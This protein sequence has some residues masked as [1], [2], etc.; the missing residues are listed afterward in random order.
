MKFTLHDLLNRHRIVV[1]LIQR[2]Y[3]Q[4]RVTEVDLRKNFIGKIKHSLNPK[5]IPLNLDFVYG[6]TDKIGNDETIFIPLD[7]QQRLTTL[8]LTYWYLAPRES[9]KIN[10][11]DAIQ[12]SEEIQELL[13]GFTYETRISS[14]RFCDS[15]INKSL[16]AT[17]GKF[18]SELI[19]DASWYMASWNS[20]PTIISMLNMID[21]IQNENFDKEESWNQLVINKKV[22]FDYID[23]KSDE[24]KLTDELYIKMNSR[25]KPL[26]SFENFKAQFSG[27]LSSKDTNYNEESLIFQKSNVTYQ[28]YFAFKIDSVWMDLFWNYRDEVES[29]DDSFLNYIFFVGEF[30]FFKDNPTIT[31]AEVKHDFEFLNKIF[32][33]KANIDFLFKSFDFLAELGDIKGFFN[34]LFEELS[35]FDTSSKDYFW[36]AITNSSFDVIDKAIFYSVLTYCI[37]R[38]SKIPDNGLK[39]FIRIIRNQLLA[40]RQPNQTK[41]IEFT[42]NL[43]LPSV[44]E[45]CKF[46]DGL[47]K[48]I[49]A[50][51]QKTV[52]QVFA[53]TELSGFTK[54]NI[55]NEKTKAEF[56]NSNPNLSKNIFRL[57]EHTFIQGNTANFKL[58]TKDASKK[59]DAFLSIWNKEA[60]DSLIIRAFLTVGDFSVMTHSYS[61]LDEIWYFGSAGYWNRILT[62][63]E[64]VEREKVSETLNLFLESYL[65]AKGNSANEKLQFLI[66]NYSFDK[67]NWQ[68]YFVK[69]KPITDFMYRRI[70]L[71]TWADEDGFEINSIGNSGKQPLHSYH[72]NP[73]L[74]VLDKYFSSDNNVTLYYQRFAEISYLKIAERV[75]IQCVRQGWRISPFENFALSRD[76]ISKYNLTKQDNIFI[77]TTSDQVDRIEIAI[78]LIQ[79]L[80]NLE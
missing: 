63:Y 54:E 42:T 78:H 22:T 47:L 79:D 34:E 7:G 35:N 74:I 33:V 80:L 75:V 52:Y 23:I 41:R 5:S 46:I 25:G 45:Y 59:I 29:I 37:N 43:R 26:T 61:S 15:L 71:F 67:K 19:K 48:A 65:K 27:L 3:A 58:N 11:E 60:D 8:W 72:L 62:A 44:S 40:V 36:R 28:Q 69:Y 18:L 57:E 49:I 38:N 68:Y 32:S 14:K 20:D 77:L 56:I 2:D 17:D 76:T 53:S 4:G 21:S 73:Y 64:K 12:L 66:D 70:N 24:F 51:K 16:P 13:S 9:V 55:S 10:E 1:P 31:S 39:H 50:S 6:Y 30:L